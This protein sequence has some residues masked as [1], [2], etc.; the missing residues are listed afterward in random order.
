MT[1]DAKIEVGLASTATAE[2]YAAAAAAQLDVYGTGGGKHHHDSL[3]RKT[4]RSDTYLG[5]GGGIR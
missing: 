3:W 4:S 1:A 2:Q 5:K